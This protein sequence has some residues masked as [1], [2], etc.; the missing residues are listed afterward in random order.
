MNSARSSGL[1]VT[2]VTAGP[3]LAGY[4]FSLNTLIFSPQV[5]VATTPLPHAAQVAHGRGTQ[6]QQDGEGA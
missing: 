2:V 1:L 5:T 6:A 3:V 4:Q